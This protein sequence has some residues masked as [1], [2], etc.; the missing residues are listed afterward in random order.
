MWTM[1]ALK[2]AVVQKCSVKCFIKDFTKFTGKNLRRSFFLNKVA[3][4]DHR[5]F[6]LNFTNS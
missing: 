5:Y 1:S 2:E 4:L 3:D 6:L